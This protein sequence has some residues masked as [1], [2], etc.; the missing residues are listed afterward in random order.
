MA[1]GD[2]FD[3]SAQAIIP[4]RTRRGGGRIASGKLLHLN[5]AILGIIRVLGIVARREQ[6]LSRQIPVVVVLIREV[7]IGRELVP[8]IDDTTIGRA[9]ANWVI[10]KT[11][12]SSSKG[13]LAALSRA[14]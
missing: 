8:G 5:Q 14:S 12:G 6:R 4:I 3:P 10:R 1:V 7:G 11:C 13:W 9:V 2:L